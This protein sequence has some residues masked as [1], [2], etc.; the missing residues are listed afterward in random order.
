MPE[1]KSI[2][3]TPTTRE[4]MPIAKEFAEGK[5]LQV[6]HP[7]YE[8][9]ADTHKILEVECACGSIVIV[10]AK[11]YQTP[12]GQQVKYEM[13]LIPARLRGLTNEGAER[14]KAKR[15]RKRFHVKKK[16]KAQRHHGIARFHSCLLF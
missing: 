6:V 12:D 3:V 16:Q 5:G 2:G 9:V 8:H 7:F 10:A 1:Y 11:Y 14:R 15:K 4:L 13:E